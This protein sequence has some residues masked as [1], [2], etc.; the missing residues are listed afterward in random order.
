MHRR[1]RTCMR[2]CPQGMTWTASS[3]SSTDF[4]FRSLRRLTKRGVKRVIRM[5]QTM[6][7]EVC[8]SDTEVC[9]ILLYDVS[10]WVIIAD[11]TF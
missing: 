3:R 1:R 4:V 11:V 7:H 10:L 9:I 2:S 5:L 6:V 8:P